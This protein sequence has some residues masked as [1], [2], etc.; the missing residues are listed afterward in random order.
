MI[1]KQERGEAFAIL[2]RMMNELSSFSISTTGAEGATLRTAIGKVL[3]NFNDMLLGEV[4]GTELFA[5]FELARTAGATLAS[6][7]RVRVAMFAEVPIYELGLAMV[8]AGVI[9]SLVEQSQIIAATEFKSQL[10][11]NVVIDRMNVVIE[12]TKLNKAD[13]FTMGDYQNFIALSALLI[14]HLATTA[15]QLPRIV[16]YHM[17]FNYPAL[18][19]SNRIYGVGSRSDE[20]IAENKTVHPAFMQR[21]VIALSE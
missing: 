11:V 7:D 10:D 8:N 21:D 16:Q 19:L 13:T 6:M 5:C 20:L 14:Q 18:A 12:E 17:P 15:L 9:F 1:L 3:S 2:T 4:I